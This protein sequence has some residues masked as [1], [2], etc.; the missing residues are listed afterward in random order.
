MVFLRIVAAIALCSIPFA[1][2][3]GGDTSKQIALLITVIGFP[4]FFS[5][6][7]PNGQKGR[8]VGI[9]LG[10]SLALFA[11]TGFYT[12]ISLIRLF[13]A[14]G[15]SW[16]WLWTT[17]AHGLMFATAIGVKGR[18]NASQ[19]EVPLY[20]CLG[21]FYSICSIPLGGWLSKFL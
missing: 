9:A 17:L 3:E 10:S 18:V 21:F 8:A 6:V 15:S 11:V 5:M 2:S 14:P 16:P 13:P 1:L 12:L 4:H 19:G 7:V 20:A